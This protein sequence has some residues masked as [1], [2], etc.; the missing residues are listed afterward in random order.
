MKLTFGPPSL[1]PIACAALVALTLLPRSA[2]VQRSVR[3]FSA[4]S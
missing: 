2:Q 4:P 1:R 3:Q